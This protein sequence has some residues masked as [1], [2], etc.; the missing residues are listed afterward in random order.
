M[1]VTKSSIIIKIITFSA[2]LLLLINIFQFLF[3]GSTLSNIIQ[4]E[5]DAQFEESVTVVFQTLEQEEKILQE[6]LESFSTDKTV[7]LENRLLVDDSE[8]GSSIHNLKNKYRPEF[9]R[10]AISALEGV[11]Y[12]KDDSL[13]LVL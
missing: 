13:N 12:N 1:K 6:T 10:N 11:Y 9:Q 5:K 7:S 3:V 2:V 8:G 4:K